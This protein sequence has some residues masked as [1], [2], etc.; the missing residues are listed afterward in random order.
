MPKIVKIME[1]LAESPKSWEEAAQNVVAEASQTLHN[2]RSVYTVYIKEFSAS[3]CGKSHELPRY[4][5][6]N[7]RD[8]ARR[9]GKTL[10]LKSGVEGKGDCLSR[11]F[12]G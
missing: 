6:S 8:G 4:R 11:R 9:S 7:L 1:I 2:V 12:A 10:R 5:E 3:R